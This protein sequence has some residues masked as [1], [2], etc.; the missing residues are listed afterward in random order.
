ME[1][2]YGVLPDA[3]RERYNEVQGANLDPE[4]DWVYTED[5]KMLLIES[6]GSFRDITAHAYAT[7]WLIWL[8][9]KQYGIH[10]SSRFNMET[11]DCT[12]YIVGIW[13][14]EPLM[15]E[16]MELIESCMKYYLEKDDEKQCEIW[17]KRHPEREEA[18]RTNYEV[19]TLTNEVR[20]MDDGRAFD[21][22]L[23]GGE[24]EL[25]LLEKHGLR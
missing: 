3:I 22:N 25:K 21:I 20:S 12:Y 16:Q 10:T 13:G 19:V 14:G 9:E 24:P 11:R 23:Y 18:K 4:E 7:V 2:R 17:N 5:G 8:N 6:S 15:D 1:L